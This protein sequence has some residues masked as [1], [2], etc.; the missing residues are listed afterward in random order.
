MSENTHSAEEKC[1][2]CAGRLAWYGLLDSF[3]L[4]IFKGAAGLL[5]HSS[6]LT[7]S[8]VYSL[9]D[10]ISEIAIL[11][12]LK[13]S[14]APA[15]EEHPY[16]HGEMENVVSVFNGLVIF[17]STIFLMYESFQLLMKGH[18]EPLHWTALGAAVIATVAN[19]LIARYDFCAYKHTTR[20]R[21][22]P[23]SSPSWAPRWAGISWTRWSPFS[24]RSTSSS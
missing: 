23:P 10:V 13:I 18:G 24:R 6:A 4:M 2:R 9:H 1:V 12:G 14:A 21:P 11:F 5:T 20:S 19:E 16:G 8:A 22:W 7:M 17:G 3:F 15:N